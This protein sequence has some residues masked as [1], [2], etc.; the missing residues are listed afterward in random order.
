MTGIS[1]EGG[2]HA[3]LER[4][5]VVTPFRRAAAVSPARS[6]HIPPLFE[7]LTGHCGIACPQPFEGPQT[8]GVRQVWRDDTGNQIKVRSAGLALLL[9]QQRRAEHCDHA[10]PVTVQLLTR[11]QPEEVDDD[12]SAQPV[13]ACC[14]CRNG[15]RCLE[16]NERFG[17]FRLGTQRVTKVG[18]LG[19]QVRDG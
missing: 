2:K 17:G 15:Y 14:L 4:L 3:T 7:N 10:R 9:C 6:T 8:V 16:G 1:N 5:L 18:P 11:M 13:R 12:L 19:G